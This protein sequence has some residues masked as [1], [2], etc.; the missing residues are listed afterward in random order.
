MRTPFYSKTALDVLALYAQDSR[1]VEAPDGDGRA[2]AGNISMGYLP[3]QSS[4]ASRFFPNLQRTFAEID[5]VVDWKTMGPRISAAYD[6]IG[7]RPD[8]A[9]DRRGPLLLH[10]CLGRRH[11]RWHQSERQLPGDITGGTISTATAVSSLA[12]RPVTPVISRVDASTVS[13]DPDYLRPYTDEF[14]GGVDHEL[15]PGAAAE[16]ASA[17]IASSATRRRRRTRRIRTTRS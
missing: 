13:R 2:C 14:T 17:R 8:R 4:P 11:P 5:D 1:V 15:L 9:E 3:E 12:N 6:L 7:Q 10:D 16:R